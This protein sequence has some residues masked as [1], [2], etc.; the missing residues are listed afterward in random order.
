[1]PRWKAWLCRFGMPGS[2]MAWRSS[3]AAGAAPGVT[4]A[5]APAVIDHL[6][7][8]GPARGQ[9]RVRRNAVAVMIDT[10]AGQNR[11]TIICLDI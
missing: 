6:H 10:P 3:P 11:V 5:I 7:V 4:S 2:A 1:M 8:I 9:E